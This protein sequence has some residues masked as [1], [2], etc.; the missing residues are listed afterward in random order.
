[1]DGVPD[2]R[3]VVVQRKSIIYSKMF[4]EGKFDKG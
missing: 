1:M 2:L 4:N 3:R